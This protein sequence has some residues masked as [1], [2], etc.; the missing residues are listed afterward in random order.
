MTPGQDYRDVFKICEGTSVTVCDDIKG[1]EA[2]KNTLEGKSL[3]KSYILLP[4]VQG[5]ALYQPVVHE[6]RVP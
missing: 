6:I 5:L 1:L 4:H 3:N 2:I